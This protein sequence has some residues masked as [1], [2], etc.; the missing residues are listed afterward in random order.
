VFGYLDRRG[1][2]CAG[3]FGSWGYGSMEDAIREGRAA[4][5]RITTSVAARG[6]A[7]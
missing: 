6:A 3:R 5:E 1:V 4:A 7:G 2:H